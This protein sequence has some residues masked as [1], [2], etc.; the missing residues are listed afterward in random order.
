MSAED[1]DPFTE[2]WSKEY[3]TVDPTTASETLDTRWKRELLLADY[4]DAGA[5]ARNA[6]TLLIQSFYVS[7]VLFGAISTLGY[8]LYV[9]GDRGLFLLAGL[10]G[11]ALFLLLAN[12]SARYKQGRDASWDRQSEIEDYVARAEPHLLRGND[13]KFKRLARLG[14]GEYEVAG[15]EWYELGSVAVWVVAAETAIGLLGLAITIGAVTV[16]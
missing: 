7:L 4:R 1:P 14:D 10:V 3:A 5:D 8:R 6:E 15:Q 12:W 9:N 13:S 16:A 2:E 11:S